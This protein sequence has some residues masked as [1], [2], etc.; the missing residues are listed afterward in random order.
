MRFWCTIVTVLGIISVVNQSPV[1]ASSGLQGDCVNNLLSNSGFEAGF[2]SRAGYFGNVAN[3]WEPF[4]FYD[5][6]SQSTNKVPLYVAEDRSLHSGN[7]AQKW[8]SAYTTTTAGLWQR[9]S[10]QSGSRVTF[11]AWALGW[12]GNADGS[13]FTAGN[14]H[15]RVGIDPAGGNNSFA[16]N[17]QWSGYQ[18]PGYNQWVQS[19]VTT[20]AQSGQ[21]TLFLWANQD[22]PARFNVVWWDDACLVA[23]VPTPTPRPPTPTPTN[24]PVPTA[25]PTP[26]YTPTPTATPTNTPT[27]TPT[28]TPTPTPTPTPQPL[29]PNL[30]QG[31]ANSSGFL[32][33]GLALALAAFYWGLGRT[34]G[35]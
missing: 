32:V 6:A 17:I 2:S 3:G 16:A 24:T 18:T 30:G 13:D 22:Y 31:V 7:F 28:A 14:Q 35:Q 1:E 10:V 8:E 34:R 27:P 25:T 11:S 9:V 21:V 33:L 20:T 12:S 5:Q 4:Y 26:T 29:L 19:S 23:V 15:F